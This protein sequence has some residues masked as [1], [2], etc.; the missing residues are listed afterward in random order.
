LEIVA[1]V[2]FDQAVVDV[3]EPH[4]WKTTAKIQREAY[5][6]LADINASAWLQLASELQRDIEQQ[7]RTE[8]EAFDLDYDGA[9]LDDLSGSKESEDPF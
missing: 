4:P 7:L 2:L 6:G 9:D 8:R 1:C 5:R 3:A